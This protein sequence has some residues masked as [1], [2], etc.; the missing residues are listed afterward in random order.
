MIRLHHP[1]ETQYKLA[2]VEHNQ[3]GI[4]GQHDGGMLWNHSKH[5]VTFLCLLQ[6]EQGSRC[7][8]YGLP[9]RNEISSLYSSTF[10]TEESCSPQAKFKGSGRIILIHLQNRDTLYD[11]YL[12]L[13]NYFCLLIGD[14][15]ECIFSECFKI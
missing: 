12:C 1:S 9:L 13:L 7:C 3:G 14:K 5:L 8:A 4:V 15:L 6:H 11:P 10:N 2:F